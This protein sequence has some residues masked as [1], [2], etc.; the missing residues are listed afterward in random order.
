MSA[1][2]AAGDDRDDPARR[3]LPRGRSFRN[4]RLRD[5]SWLEQPRLGGDVGCSLVEPE[6]RV[7]VR[8]QPGVGG[9]PE[10][11]PVEAEHEV[12]DPPRDTAS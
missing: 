4:R 6:R 11:P 2:D 1:E 10:H 5:R 3:P 7:A 8:H 9:Y 12:E